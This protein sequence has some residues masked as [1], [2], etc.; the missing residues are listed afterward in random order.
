MWCPTPKFR[1]TES[2]TKIRISVFRL[3]IRIRVTEFK[4]TEGQVSGQRKNEI[5][6]VT[7]RFDIEKFS[8]KIDFGLWRIKMKTL[9]VHQGLTNALNSDS[10]KL[11]T[12]DVEKLSSDAAERDKMMEKAHSACH[13]SMSW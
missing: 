6:M 3:R 11:S 10:G 7:N 8:E 4:I 12:A 9:L 1:I 2:V 13:H 5:K